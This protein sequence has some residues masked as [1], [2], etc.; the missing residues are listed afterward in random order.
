MPFDNTSS[1]DQRALGRYDDG[2]APYEMFLIGRS[3]DTTY[4]QKARGHCSCRHADIRFT[5]DYGFF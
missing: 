5:P 2:V 1:E 4:S 3:A